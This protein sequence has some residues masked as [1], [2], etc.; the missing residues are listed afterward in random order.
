MRQILVMSSLKETH[1]GDVITLCFLVLKCLHQFS[2][3]FYQK[4]GL[5][6]TNNVSDIFS[7]TLCIMGKLDSILATWSN[8]PIRSIRID[9]MSL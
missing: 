6:S 7:L 4:Q 5:P 8:L 9:G 2:N 1:I 3:S